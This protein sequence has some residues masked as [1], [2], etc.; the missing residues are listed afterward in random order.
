LAGNR[1]PS[2]SVGKFPDAVRVFPP[3]VIRSPKLDQAAKGISC[4]LAKQR[5]LGASHYPCSTLFVSCVTR[6]SQVIVYLSNVRTSFTRKC[7]DIVYS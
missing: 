3:D 1:V 4:E 6:L 2:A 5:A 7:H